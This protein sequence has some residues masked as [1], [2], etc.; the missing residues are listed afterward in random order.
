[1]PE[2]CP[3]VQQGEQVQRHHANQQ[4]N[5]N[6]L[7]NEIVP[8]EDD[9]RGNRRNPRCGPIAVIGKTA[10]AGEGCDGS[11]SW[12]ADPATFARRLR[13]NPQRL[14]KENDDAASD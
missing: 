2:N 1:V 12:P 10:M 6:R 13:G 11:V 5:N 8:V 4:R 7:M 14:V 3:V 9:N